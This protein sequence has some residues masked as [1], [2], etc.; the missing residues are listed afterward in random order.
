VT[1]LA[2]ALAALMLQAP[3]SMRTVA[4]GDQSFIESERQV[5]ARSSAEWNAIWRQHDPDRPVPAV[6]F[7]KEMVVGV[8]LG[9]RNTG[10]YSVEIVSAS[11]EQD[12][13]IVRYRQRTPPPDAIT[14]Q[15][16]TMPFQ[17]VAIPKTDAAVKFQ[18][19]Q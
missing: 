14:A 19:V 18:R 4:R 6:D 1:L 17:L 8:F 16:I 12:A 13:L 15:V 9:S 10:G 3:A 5:V 2:A 11:V 7:S